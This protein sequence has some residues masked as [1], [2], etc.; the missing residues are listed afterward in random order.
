MVGDQFHLF[1]KPS[2]QASAVLDQ[3]DRDFERQYVQPHSHRGDPLSS[4]RSGDRLLKSGR[5]R[6]QMKAVL[7]ALRCHQGS[8]SAE[9]A[10]LADMDRYTVARRLPALAAKGLV[11]RGPERLCKV[12]KSVCVTWRVK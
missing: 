4:Y 2:R 10:Q 7:E 9:L 6:G 3:P 1:V 8:T 12:C 11:E 5:I